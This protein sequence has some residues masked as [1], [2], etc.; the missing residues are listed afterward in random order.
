MLAIF[1]EAMFSISIFTARAL[2][3]VFDFGGQLKLLDVGGGGGAYPIELC[4]HFPTLSA[5]VFD[6]PHVCEIAEAKP[7]ASSRGPRAISALHKTFKN[8]P[9]LRQTNRPG[10][11][12]P[13]RHRLKSVFN[14]NG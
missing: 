3:D 13:V 12:R 6:L 11:T 4:R 1:W 14:P 7:L 9:C 10:V 8:T 5:T 2:A